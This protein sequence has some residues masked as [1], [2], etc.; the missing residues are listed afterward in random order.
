MIVP[1]VGLSSPTIIL[2]MVVL[3]EPDSPTMA[4]DPASGMANET[5]STATSGPNSLRR[6]ETASAA[7]PLAAGVVAPATPV[8][9]IG[10]HLQLPAQLLSPHAPG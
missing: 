10:G 9:G 8:S 3:P 7:V 2:A 4:S 5:S 6:P 1:W